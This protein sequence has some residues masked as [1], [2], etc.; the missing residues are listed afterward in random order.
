ML[1]VQA[2]L[3]G[4]CKVGAAGQAG[5]VDD[6]RPGR[7]PL[8]KRARQHRRGDRVDDGVEPRQQRGQGCQ[9][10]GAAAAAAG[11]GALPGLRAATVTRPPS[12]ASRR[13]T[14]RPTRP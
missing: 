7:Q 10:S 1:G 4:G 12:S 9:R 3:L 14:A 5:K 11:V 6:Q 2:Q 8:Q 13:A